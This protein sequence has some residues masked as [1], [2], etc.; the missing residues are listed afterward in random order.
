MK[1]FALTVLAWLAFCD[2]A[3]AQKDPTATPVPAA[4]SE[5]MILVASAPGVAQAE[6]PALPPDA[7]VEKSFAESL[8]D[9][10]FLAKL[11]VLMGAIYIILRGLAEG[12]TRISVYTENKSVGRVA[13]VLSDVT[14]FLGTFIGKFGYGTPKHVAIE[15]AEQLAAKQA[16][17]G[18]GSDGSKPAA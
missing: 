7:W 17:K 16:A 3:V 6:A 1:L 10:S 9:G 5:S 8:L 4:A 2:I 13:K 18:P 11:A 15:Q 14:W 12:L